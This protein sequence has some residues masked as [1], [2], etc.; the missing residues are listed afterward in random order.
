[1][2]PSLGEKREM[3]IANDPWVKAYARSEI[4]R[5]SLLIPEKILKRIGPE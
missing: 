2:V 1:M 5:V 3:L 4:V